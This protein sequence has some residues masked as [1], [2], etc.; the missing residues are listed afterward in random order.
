MFALRYFDVSV[1][2][3]RWFRTI[4]TNFTFCRFASPKENLDMHTINI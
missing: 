1:G 4:Y 2:S 3:W